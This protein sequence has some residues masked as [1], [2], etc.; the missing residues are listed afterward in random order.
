MQKVIISKL[1][2]LYWCW[3]KSVSLPGRFML[4][5]LSLWI[6]LFHMLTFISSLHRYVGDN[7]TLSY[8]WLSFWNYLDQ[9]EMCSWFNQTTL[10]S[11]NW[12][13]SFSGIDGRHYNSASR[14]THSTR[15][16]PDLNLVRFSKLFYRHLVNTWS[17]V[18]IDV[19]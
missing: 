7:C 11:L 17:Y 9:T 15:T 2:L 1:V 8:P 12:R 18:M 4:L 16:F 13:I 19:L 6:F 5:V 3:H 14:P 10:T